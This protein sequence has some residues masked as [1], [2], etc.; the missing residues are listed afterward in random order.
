MESALK[1]FLFCLGVTEGGTNWVHR[2]LSQHTQF[3]FVPRK[4]IHYHLRQYGGVD[5]LSD[6]ARMRHFVESVQHF[7]LHAGDDSLGILERSS[8]AAYGM[9]WDTQ[10]LKA[11]AKNG[12]CDKRYKRLMRIIN[13]YKPYLQGPVNDAWYRSLFDKVPPNQWPSDFSTTGLMCGAEAIAHMSKL[14]EDTRAMVL[15]RDPIERL[16]S[17]VILHAEIV[18]EVDQLRRWDAVRIRQYVADFDMAAGSYYAEGIEAMVQYFAPEKRHIVNFEDLETWPDET[19]NGIYD[20]LEIPRMRLPSGAD[21]EKKTNINHDIPMPKGVFAD[22]A[23]SFV[24]DLERVQAAGVGFVAPWIARAKAHAEEVPRAA[25]TPA[26]LSVP[27]PPSAAA[28][29]GRTL[30]DRAFDYLSRR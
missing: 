24:A 14:A 9:P 10:A 7:K 21:V 19:M 11:W 23:P 3:A 15:L 28:P 29:S 22:L 16:W 13:W 2:V 30:V 20:F 27:E 25:S 17:H 5:R 18:G 6:F 8:E 1:K 4:E 12:P 26:E